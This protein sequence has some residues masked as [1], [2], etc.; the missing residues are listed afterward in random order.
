MIT[1]GT[2]LLP[3]DER[4]TYIYIWSELAFKSLLKKVSTVFKW[5][6][7]DLSTST[8]DVAEILI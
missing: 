1:K 2:L 6:F 8:I 5:Y 7:I 4:K 3:P